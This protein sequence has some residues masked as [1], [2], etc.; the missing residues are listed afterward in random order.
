MPLQAIRSRSFSDQV[1][2]Q[3]ATEILAGA[4]PPGTNLPSERELTE[5]LQVNRHVVREALR[6]LEQVGLAKPY[7][8]GGTRVTDFKRRAGLELLATMA[9]HAHTGEETLGLWLAVLEMRA[10]IGGDVARL[11]ALRG[12]AEQRQKLVVIARAIKDAPDDKQMLRED[13]RFWDRVVDGAGNIAY[14][15][16]TNTL[17]K[18][19]AIV[20]ETADHWI[21]EEL[22]GSDYRQAI[23]KAIA[24]GDAKRAE[25]RTHE[26]MRATVGRF[27]SLKR[28]VER[29]RRRTP[30]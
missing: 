4:Y 17:D 7:Q 5:I 1:F 24:A 20:G 19:M 28:R 27:E 6:R 25:A 3:L 13:E 21:I 30:T 18:G 23:A 15:L 2:R 29:T 10:A 26:A 12:P 11:C 8:G 9:E 16:A 22:K 14:R